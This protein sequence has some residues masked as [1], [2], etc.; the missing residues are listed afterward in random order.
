MMGPFLG[1]SIDDSCR[2]VSLLGLCLLR[3]RG[4]HSGHPT[5]I[6]WGINLQY[7][8]RN[9]M[10]KVLYNL[11]SKP[12]GLLSKR[13]SRRHT[14]PLE[15]HC[16]GGLL[17][18]GGGLLFGGGLL[19]RLYS[20]IRIHCIFTIMSSERSEIMLHLYVARRNMSSSVSIS[21]KCSGRDTSSPQTIVQTLKRTNKIFVNPET[22]GGGVE[23]KQNNPTRNRKPSDSYV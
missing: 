23:L 8:Q 6:N 21:F 2:L 3:H 15:I 9:R 13:G 1:D 7:M 14:C 11:D 17:L 4:A 12:G 5:I 18:R 16:K 10:F 22:E 19:S 20:N